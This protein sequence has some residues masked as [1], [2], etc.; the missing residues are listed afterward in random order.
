MLARFAT[1]DDL[2]DLVA[3]H[4]QAWRETYPGLLPEEMI[5]SMTSPTRL[6][7]LWMSFLKRE[8]ARVAI[9]SGVGFAMIGPQQDANL[10]SSGYPSELWS[11]YLLRH[12]QGRGLGREMVLHL[13]PQVAFTAAVLE[14]NARA[15]G[16]YQKSGG[17]VIGRK[18]DRIGETEV[19]DLI[20]AWREGE[21][22]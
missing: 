13:K 18:S 22:K 9:I 21:F 3:I 15:I 14:G 10:A 12:E 4:A 8:D 5:D 17:K 19:V 11:L 7:T 16:F 20:Y 6:A 2:P 1:I